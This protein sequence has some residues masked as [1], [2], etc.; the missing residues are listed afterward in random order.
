M[1]QQLDL[2]ARRRQRLGEAAERE[3]RGDLGRPRDEPRET[4][5]GRPERGRAGARRCATSRSRL[6]QRHHLRA[7]EFVGSPAAPASSMRARRRQRDV[8]DEDRLQFRRAAAEQRQRRQNARERGEAVEEIVLRPEHDRRAQHDRVGRSLAQRRRLRRGPCWRYRDCS[9]RRRRRC[10]RR[11]RACRRP[12]RK[13]RGRSRRRRSVDRL[14]GLRPLWRLI[15]GDVDDGVGALDRRLDRIRDSAG[16]PAPPGLA[17]RRRAAAGTRRSPAAAP[18]PARAS[19]RAPARARYGARQS[20]N[21][22]KPSPDDRCYR[23]L[24]PSPLD[25]ALMSSAPP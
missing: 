24:R 22:R 4:P 9:T 7:A 23:G 6:A 17:R 8:A 19:P 25:S 12:P 13:P 10:P 14:V 16:W 3:R 21:R 5:N 18:P 11:G 1:T 2:V 20:P 15:A